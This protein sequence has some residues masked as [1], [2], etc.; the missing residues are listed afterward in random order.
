MHI[1][2]QTSLVPQQGSRK[3]GLVWGP[4]SPKTAPISGGGRARA[5]ALLLGRPETLNPTP[6]TL[7]PT[8]YTLHP[9]PYTLHPTPYTLHPKLY[10]LH[11]TPYTLR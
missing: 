3:G 11:L 5:A 8:P 6:Y 7:H 2:K 9:T 4:P 10:T 1:C